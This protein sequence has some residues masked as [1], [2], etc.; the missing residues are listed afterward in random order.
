MKLKLLRTPASKVIFVVIVLIL[1]V[2]R[3]GGFVEFGPT[4]YGDTTKAVEIQVLYPEGSGFKNISDK[5]PYTEGSTAQSVLMDYGRTKKVSVVLA[6]G[7]A[8]VRGIGG[9][10]ERDLGDTF[11]W[12]YTVS[13]ESPMVS[14]AEFALEGK[15]VVVWEYVDYNAVFK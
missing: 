2:L 6:A 14:A 13:G 1:S 11:G 5:V 12:V 8:Y 9:L 10:M 3:F 7:N 15:E 4:L